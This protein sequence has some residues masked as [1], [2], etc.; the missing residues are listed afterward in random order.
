MQTKIELVKG[1]VIDQTV[2]VIVNAANAQLQA[3]GSSDGCTSCGCLSVI[4]LVNVIF[5][6]VSV[7]YC[8]ESFLNKTV[9]FWIALI[10]GLFL[11]EFTIPLAIVC[12]I[13]RSC[14]IQSPFIHQ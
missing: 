5:G 10:V 2:D 14:G 8:L 4:F 11:G 7:N 1:S 3:G 9:D 12:W 13:L 6:A